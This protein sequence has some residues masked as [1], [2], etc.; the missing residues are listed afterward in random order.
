MGAE[1]GSIGD[2]IMLAKWIIV[3]LG[4]KD[5]INKLTYSV[6]ENGREAEVISLSEANDWLETPND[7]RR[8]VVPAGSIWFNKTLKHQRPNYIGAWHDD[9]L[10][11]CTRY[12]GYWGKY[13][14][15]QNYMMM[16][17]GEII[18]RHEE[19]H[20]H[21]DSDALFYRPNS[22]EKDFTGILIERER[23]E[24]WYKGIY[25]LE[26][27]TPDLLC[28]VAPPLNIHKELRL[29]IKGGKVITG[30]AYKVA[31][32]IWYDALEEQD[33]RDEIIEFAEKVANDNPPP[34][35]PAYIMDV[36]KVATP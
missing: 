14:A 25:A 9:T 4:S 8:C 23:F 11:A 20:K 31:K 1:E 17:F 35:P 2:Q 29:L 34:L 22:G 3:N 15:Q 16:P 10:F 32:H 21:F 5:N 19:L 26:Q 27:A 33:D 24:N 6:L 7:E 28:V 12:Y 18:R 13:I 30:S 36:A